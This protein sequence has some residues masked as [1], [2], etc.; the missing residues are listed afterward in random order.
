MKLL[1]VSRR[2]AMRLLFL[3]VTAVSCAQRALSTGTAGR[4][5]SA[6]HSCRCERA[7]PNWNMNQR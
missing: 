7:A 5:G 4:N 2:A 3:L 1:A 6:G